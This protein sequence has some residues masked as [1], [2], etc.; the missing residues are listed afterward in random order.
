[1]AMRLPFILC[2]LA[3]V[4]CGGDDPSFGGG[5]GTASTGG[6]GGTASGT[7]TGSGAGGAGGQGG[8]AACIDFGEPCSA[9]ELAACSDRYCACYDNLDCG[10][11]ASCAVECAQNDTA[12]LQA[13]NSAY[14]NGISD[15]VLL[16]DCAATSCPSECADFAL[17]ELNACQT[18]LYDSCAPAMNGCLSVPDCAGL[19]FCLDGCAGDGMCENGCYATYPGGVEAAVPVG[20]CSMQSCAAECG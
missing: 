11:Y 15:A 13:C 12:C 17:Y 19:L 18:C 16:N 5:G 3:T 8:G 6:S 14:P 9:C 2:L 1:M 7:A 10:L 4:A 20:S